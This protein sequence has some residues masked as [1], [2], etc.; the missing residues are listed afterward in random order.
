MTIS[1]ARGAMHFSAYPGSDSNLEN[2]I[3][4]HLDTVAALRSID[5]KMASLIVL[6]AQG[7]NLSECASRLGMS[8]STMSRRMGK[9]RRNFY[10]EVA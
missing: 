5:G 10:T 1:Q 8:I 4:D 9:L 2:L 6:T 7:Y 3:I